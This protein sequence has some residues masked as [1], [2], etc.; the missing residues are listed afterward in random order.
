MI[1][2][3]A[4]RSKEQSVGQHVVEMEESNG[5]QSRRKERYNYPRDSLTDDLNQWQNEV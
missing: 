4:S 1:D 2:G 5:C 3:Q